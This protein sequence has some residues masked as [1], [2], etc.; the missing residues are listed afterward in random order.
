M[1]KINDSINLS[2][3]NKN[4]SLPPKVFNIKVNNQAIFDTILFERASRR[5]G[6]HKVKNRSE[7]RGGGRKPFAQ[8]HTGKARA[9]SIRSPIWVGG[10]IIFGPNPNKN[11]NLKINKKLRKLAFLSSL[12]LKSKKQ[13]II[14]DEIK[15]N[16]ISTKE[17]IRKI[18]LLKLKEVFKKILIVSESKILYKSANNLKKIEVQ[19]LSCLNIEKIINADAMIISK[20]D[21]KKIEG[22]VK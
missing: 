19:K 8:K 20:S 7:V 22:M 13:A 9:G 12:T 6:N 21:I 4:F 1:K 3:K 10:G 14:I 18:N 17:F 2:K 16:K 15:M 5:K 11:Y